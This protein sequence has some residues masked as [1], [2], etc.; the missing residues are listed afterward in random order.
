MIL[1]GCQIGD[2]DKIEQETAYSVIQEYKIKHENNNPLKDFDE[3]WL[4]K[5]ITNKKI[6]TT[7]LFE[8]KEIA[9]YFED[10]TQPSVKYLQLEPAPEGDAPVVKT[11]VVTKNEIKPHAIEGE[12]KYI[13]PEDVQI[14]KIEQSDDKTLITAHL[15]INKEWYKTQIQE[16]VLD[17]MLRGKTR[18][19]Y[20]ESKNKILVGI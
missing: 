17:L 20:D 11:Q 19:Y 1:I 15:K 12:V 14:I 9:K 7:T 18:Y 10:I 16:T 6:K 8:T 4:V 3:K 13:E 2:I 5:L